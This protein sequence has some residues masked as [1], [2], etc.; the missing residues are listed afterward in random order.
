MTFLWFGALLLVTAVVADNY[1]F[2]TKEFEDRSAIP[3]LSNGQLGFVVYSD[4]VHLN[5]LYNGKTGKSHRARIPNYARVQYE[6]CGIYTSGA[7]D[8]TYSLDMR[9]GLFRTTSNYQSNAYSVELLTFPHRFY[10]KTIVNQLTI[11][12]TVPGVGGMFRVRLLNLP[13]SNSL[14][15]EIVEEVTGTVDVSG[16]EYTSY[17]KRTLE[18][19]DARYQQHTREFF[20]ITAKVPE[21]VELQAN[22]NVATFTWLTSIGYEYEHTMLEFRQTSQLSAAQLLSSHVS[23]WETFW[24]EQ[25]ITVEGDDEVAK[26][27]HSSLFFLTSALPA[28]RAYNP[29]RPPFYGLAP[30]GLGKG[31]VVHEEYQGHSFWD[32]EIWMLPPILLLEPKWSEWVLSY[33]Y[34][35]KQAA[36]DNAIETGYKGLRFPWEGGYTGREVTPDCCPQNPMYQ[37]HIIGDIAFAARAHFYA[38]LDFPWFSS[39]GCELAYQ[40]AEFWESRVKFNESSKLYDI[41]GKK[42]ADKLRVDTQ[43]IYCSPGI[44]GP[45]EDHY[46]TTNNAFTNVIAAY[47]LFFGE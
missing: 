9:R 46:F 6:F 29:L 33:R 14:D 39:E 20:V 38:T 28:L 3:T 16:V 13:G 36:A 17:S 41:V 47:N 44:M 21:V 31:G 30:S 34:R 40:T 10:E 19:E 7:D 18:V 11:K 23:V 45:D 4:S 27:I 25:G 43:C 12:R 1:V 2:D 15:L 8:C 22:E 35:T 24:T 42:L 5:G 26:S 37:Q 32:T